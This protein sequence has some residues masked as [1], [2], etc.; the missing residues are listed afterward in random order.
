MA[1]DFKN[2]RAK[3]NKALPGW[4]WL[5][6]GLT[7]GLFV[8]LLVYLNNTPARMGAPHLTVHKA[9]PEPVKK[10]AAAP[11][12]TTKTEK[13][14]EKQ[15]PPKPK[16]DFYTLLPELEVVVPDGNYTVHNENQSGGNAQPDKPGE[17]VL[18]VGSFKSY[19]QAD[20]M[21]ARLALLGVHASIQKVSV[22]NDTWHRVR[23]GPYKDLAQLNKIRELLA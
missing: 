6:A 18:Q 22:N 4:A 10:A 14:A 23:I 16:F 15:S 3:Q 21:K 1:R 2:S 20:S 7:I 12:T 17:Y 8:A 11:K 9:R 5:L 13:S 19:D